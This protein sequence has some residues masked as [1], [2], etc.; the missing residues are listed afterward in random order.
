MRPSRISRRVETLSAPGFR[1]QT[2]CLSLL[3]SQ[4][5]LKQLPLWVVECS[6]V[7]PARIS[8]R[9]ETVLRNASMLGSPI[10]FALESQ[11]GLKH[12]DVEFVINCDVVLL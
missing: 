1:G 7:E 3:E 8:R 6:S 11:E 4:E 12:D 10:Y 9:V 5:G 2:R